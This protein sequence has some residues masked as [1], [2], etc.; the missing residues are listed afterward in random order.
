[1]PKW[2]AVTT[3][4]YVRSN[5]SAGLR[6]HYIGAMRSLDTVSNPTSTTPGTSAYHL[7]DL[8]GTWKID[9]RI[10]LHGGV[11]NLLNRDP[12][13]VDGAIGNT[14]ASTYDV[15]GRAFFIAVRANL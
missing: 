12:P 13:V 11:N 10:S 9:D 2:K 5:W 14:E 6:W 15:L 4:S 1:L 8:F 7:L 3:G